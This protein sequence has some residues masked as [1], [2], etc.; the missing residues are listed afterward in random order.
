[1]PG[2]PRQ[3]F[4]ISEF[5]W[6]R[7]KKKC[8]A[9]GYTASDVLRAFIMEIVKGSVSVDSVHPSKAIRGETLVNDDMLLEWLKTDSH[10]IDS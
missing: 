2:T 5:I 3:T 6:E 1:M 8:A 7:F 10:N 9:K 4:R